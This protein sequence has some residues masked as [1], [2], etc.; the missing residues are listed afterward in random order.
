VNDG[1]APLLVSVGPPSAGVWVVP[2]QPVVLDVPV[3][4][5]VLTTSVWTFE[6]LVELERRPVVVTWG[7]PCHERV[8]VTA[9]AR[10]GVT[11]TNHERRAV[12]VVVDGRTVAV[13]PPWS[14][15]A[16]ELPAGRHLVAIVDDRGRLLYHAPA[17]LQPYTDHDVRVAGGI[18]VT[19]VPEGRP[20]A[21]RR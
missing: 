18:T 1:Q 8:G 20:V 2:G 10:S 19:P 6:G 11:I 17:F 12:S 21:W 14:S 13:V 3:G 15:R 9:D 7:K 16:F 4:R 5:T